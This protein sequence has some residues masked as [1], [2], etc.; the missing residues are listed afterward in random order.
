MSCSTAATKGCSSC[1]QS[2]TAPRMPPPHRARVVDAEGRADARLPVLTLRDDRP[3]VDAHGSRPYRLPHVD[4]GR[5]GDEHVRVAHRVGQARLLAA[6][7]QVVEQHARAGGRVPG[8]TRAPRRPGGRRRRGARPRC[9]R[10]A[11]RRP[12]PARPARRRAR[13][14]PRSGWPA[15]PG[16]RAPTT[17]RLPDAV[18]TPSATRSPRAW[19]SST[20]AVRGTRWVAVPS[21][22]NVP[23]QVAVALLQPGVAAQHDLVA[24]ERHQLAGEPGRPVQHP[25]PGGRLPVRVL[26]GGAGRARRPAP[27]GSRPARC[28]GSCPA[29]SPGSVAPPGVRDL[30]PPGVRDPARPG[31]RD[32]AQASAV[33]STR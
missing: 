7:D 1:F 16:P 29:R 26:R 5:P 12:T 23:G 20:G 31:V 22:A 6:G 14:R 8:R 19:T 30:A 9:P 32:P 13:P 21:T 28:P 17:A 24:V 10:C 4:V 18:R 25:D 3:R 27:T 11:G 33:A 15:R 2:C